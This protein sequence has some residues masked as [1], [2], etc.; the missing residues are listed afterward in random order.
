[1]SPDTDGLPGPDEAGEL[2]REEAEE[3]VGE[4]R[5]EV[6]R[7]DH[8]YYVENDPEISDAEYD[9]LFGALETI[10]DRF[11]D[12]A[13][14]DSPTRRVGAPPRDEFPTVEHV[15]PMLSLE[16]TRERPDVDRFVE[17]VREAAGDGATFILEPKLD[18]ASVEVVYEDGRLIRAA[19][20]GDGEEGEEVTDN[21]RTIGSVPLR[22][23]EEDRRAP[24]VLA[25]RG[26]AIFFLPDF[27]EL[28]RTLMER[29]EEPFANPRNAA[30]GSLRQLDSRVTAGR[31]LHLLAYEVLAVE[32]GPELETDSGALDALDDWGFRLPEGIDTADDAEAIAEYHERWAG[33]RD[34]LDYEI[35][36]VVV[37]LDEHAPREELG[38]TAR[39]P[40]WA[41]AFKF[42][43]RR[44]ETRV[45]D[46]AI[47]VGRTGKLT[48]VALLRP[49]EVGGVT[50][51]RASLHNREEVE[52]KDVRIGDRV[53]IQRAGDVIPE[54]VERVKEPGRE[55]GAPFH[56]PSQC[57]A[58]GADVEQDGPLD[59]CPNRFECPAQLKGRIQHYA[60]R[61]AMDIEGI[62]EETANLLV[63]RGLVTSL[64]DLYRLGAEDLEDL[65]G[66][67]E[68]AAGKLVGEIED[69]REPELRRFLY[70]LGIPDVGETVARDLA[71][72]FGTLEAV[73]EADAEELQQVPGVG[74]KM[75][76]KIREFFDDP[77]D[78]EAIDGLLESGVEVR[79]AAATDTELLD[80]LTFVFT[81]A[82]ERWTRD[83]ARELV[84][85]NGGRAT[86]SVSSETDYVVVGEE[87]GRKADRAGEEGVPTLDEEE[88]AELLEEKGVEA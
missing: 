40:R 46:I 52:R 67:A 30:A 34:D 17:R 16:A 1:M 51:A 65:E 13:T 75:A 64:A 57:P 25:V 18:G 70:G 63:E 84:E 73:R 53:R 68:T 54:V 83:E 41:L 56:M 11:P 39:H 4:L 86:S 48:P 26:E 62:G 3:V 7:H 32:E 79:E 72:H 49:V 33:R 42:E 22:L 85:S 29:D 38:S 20:R 12:L 6:R 60:A 8:L 43:P 88:F 78:R 14:D 45:E 5:D 58:C 19:T 74:P 87:P 36:G 61:G 37:K 77:R 71:D 31:P 27:Q 82:L 47:S 55:R 23:R 10:E 44:E 15:A 66:F 24:S 69:S 50:V 76:A 59:F 81:G 21:V 28:N 35:D 80:G 9:R 2:S